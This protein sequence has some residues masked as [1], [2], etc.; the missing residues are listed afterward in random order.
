MDYENLGRL[1][2]LALWQNCTLD[3]W[4]CNKLAC[5][6]WFLKKVAGTG[7]EMFQEKLEGSE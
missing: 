2:G 1:V 6:S 4:H 5:C 3:P 7:E